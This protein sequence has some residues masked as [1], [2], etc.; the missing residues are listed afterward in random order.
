VPEVSV[1]N[2]PLPELTVADPELAGLVEAE[3]ARQHAS[4][5][6][7]ASENYVSTAVLEAAGSVLT[8]KYS[9]GY[10]GRRYY[11]GQQ[12]VDPIETLAVERAK[13]LF[14]VEH[15]NV[16]PYSGSPANLAVYL[17][18]AQPGDTVMGLSLPMGG[19]LTHGWSVSATGRWFRSVRY[20][21]RADTG[22]IDLDEVRDLARA[23]RPKIIFCGGTAIP[24]T[25]EFP[26]FAEIAREVGAVLVADIAHIAG[27]IA[28]GAH[29]SPVGHAPVIST[30]THKTLRGPRGA[31]LLSDAEH[32]AA[33]DK[34]VFPGLQGGP[35]NHTT[36]AIAVALKE[37]S[38]P[39]FR[40]YAQAVVANARALAE[41][42]VERGFDLVTGGTD[43]HL[44]LIDLTG[45]DIGGKP[46]AKALD[47]AGIELNYNSV[48]FD[49]RKPFDPSGI[50]LGTAAITTRGLTAAHMPLLAGWIDDV[51]K[52]AGAGDA[53]TIDRVRA[54]V[55]ELISSFPMPGF[56]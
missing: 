25:I 44:I 14:G 19:H 43:N 2:P 12:L 40:D 51:V 48:P 17:A 5:R 18:F 54:Q 29:P 32:A 55:T 33:L 38:T 20:G 28:G 10:V 15:A 49:K 56:A 36:A 50:R 41:A 1:H 37:A 21:L 9:E 22:R 45:K 3:A 46:A 23:E 8:N 39:A 26:A 6:L 47:A 31:M 52:A 35:H 7:I 53:A 4:I 24:R 16:Q 13:A 27:L 30:T 34:A 42:L 11:E